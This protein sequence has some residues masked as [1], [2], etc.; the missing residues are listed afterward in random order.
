MKKIIRVLALT[1]AFVVLCGSF[2]TI[3]YAKELEPCRL[4]GG[5]GDYRCIACGN[6]G[7]VTCDGCDGAGGA[8][9]QGDTYQGNPCDN[10][11]YTCSS[12]NGDGKNRSGDGKIIEGVCG[13][14]GGAGKLRCV[15]CRNGTP[16]WNACT[17]CGGGGKHECQVETCKVSRQ[18]GWHCPD[19]KGTGFILVGNP[20]PPPEVNDGV[21]NR[22]V[23]GDLIWIDGKSHVYSNGSVSSEP[24]SYHNVSFGTG[25]WKIGDVTVT[26]DKTGTQKISTIEIITLTNF[27]PDTMEVRVGAE[28]RFGLILKVTN[29]KTSISANDHDG[30]IPYDLTFMVF[31][32]EAV[33][34]GNEGDDENNNNGDNPNQAGKYIVWFGEGSWKIGDVTVT[35]DKTNGQYLTETDIITLTNFDPDTM[36]V[37]VEAE[38]GFRTTLFVNNGKTSISAHSQTIDSVPKDIAFS[39]V[40]KEASPGGNE[41]GENNNGD[42]PPQTKTAFIVIRAANNQTGTVQYKLND[43]GDFISAEDGTSIDLNGVM[44]IT[45]KV[46]PAGEA[47]VNRSNSG[48]SGTAQAENYDYAALISE[49]GWTYQVKENDENIIF[50]IEFDNNDGMDNNPDPDNG[51]EPIVI[52]PD[53]NQDFEIPPAESGGAEKTA[54]AAVEVGKMTSEEQE[55]Y[56][57]LTDEELN[58]KLVNV[59]SILQTV[60]PGEFAAD[61][62]E[63]INDVA[64]LNGIDTL[65]E[66][67][68]FPLSFEGHEDLGFPIAVTVRLE[69][70]VLKGDSDLFVYHILEDRSIESLGK[71]EYTT[72]DDGSVE[73]ITFYT[74]GFSSF[75]TSSK[76]LNIDIPAAFPWPLLA[77][78]LVGVIVVLL[79]VTIVLRR[80]RKKV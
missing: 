78:V 36:E 32:K 30:G 65:E 68:I 9:C 67:K 72:Y 7:T 24:A 44:S 54:S 34:G 73:S 38:N 60:R 14:C 19:C 80:K 17:R 37:R 21:R 48:I 52:P 2:A 23:E 12:C 5:K 66:A 6:T 43:G 10:G 11:Y 46:A 69:K 45:I 35:A 28:D 51:E 18:Y 39:V 74:T 40:A 41:D 22:P 70:G 50:T 62:E 61:T 26:A 55:H 13:N 3:A 56:A 47:K 63:L 49:S 79:V 20:M 25:S 33:P 16:G 31:E 58:G 4:C 64:E 15:V 1:L 29:G 42:N 71:A 27:D 59:Q 8:K 77:A 75:F 57:G 53:R 76:E